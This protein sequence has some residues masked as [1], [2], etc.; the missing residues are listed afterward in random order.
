MPRLFVD[1]S[2]EDEKKK[3]TLSAYAR[4]KTGI[5]PTAERMHD[6]PGRVEKRSMTFA[7]RGKKSGLSGQ[8]CQI[9]GGGAPR[10]A[11]AWK[12]MKKKDRPPDRG[13]INK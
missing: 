10:L 5:D 13:G 11:E 3:Q 4:K 12:K 7:R 8:R 2:G 6:L 9:L 1:W